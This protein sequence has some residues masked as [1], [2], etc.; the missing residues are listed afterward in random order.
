MLN[1]LTTH[2]IRDLSTLNEKQNHSYGY[3]L[4]LRLEVYLGSVGI[5]LKELGGSAAEMFEIVS[6]D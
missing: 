3:L 2:R 5:Q 1:L 6:R 4:H